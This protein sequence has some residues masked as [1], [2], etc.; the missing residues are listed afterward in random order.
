M[1]EKEI[2]VLNVRDLTNDMIE[3][4]NLVRNH[5]ITSRDANDIANVSGKILNAAKSE[6]AYWQWLK[7]KRRIPFFECNDEHENKGCND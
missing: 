7:E 4:Y 3:V 5:K 6:L 2:K 1:A